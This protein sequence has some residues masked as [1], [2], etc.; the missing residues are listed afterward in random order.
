M[1]TEITDDLINDIFNI[2]RDGSNI[3]DDDDGPD[4]SDGGSRLPFADKVKEV[5]KDLSSLPPSPKL[6]VEKPVAENKPEPKPDVESAIKAAASVQ[7][8][9]AKNQKSNPKRK[10]RLKHQFLWNPLWKLF[11]SQTPQRFWMTI[12]RRLGKIKKLWK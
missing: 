10:L 5:V 6:E 2:P 1:K 12:P 11:K 9:L 7:T 4:I 3:S 8:Y